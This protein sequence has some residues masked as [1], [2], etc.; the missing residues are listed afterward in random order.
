MTRDEIKEMRDAYLKAEMEI[1]QGK[2]VT[3]NGQSMTM[4]NLSEIRK[5]REYWERRYAQSSATKR[6]SP[7]YK[8]A[9][10]Q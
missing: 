1:L 3:F 5:G 4:E 10:F 6:K 7:G 9:R 2:S 8:L